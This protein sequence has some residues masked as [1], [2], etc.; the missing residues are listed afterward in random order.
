MKPNG[1]NVIFEPDETTLYGCHPIEPIEKV[2][3]KYAGF[4]AVVHG[5]L[6]VRV[7]E[8]PDSTNRQAVVEHRARQQRFTVLY[9]FLQQV[10]QYFPDDVLAYHANPTSP[11]YGQQQTG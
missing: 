3:Q 6:G 8:V 1:R 5:K 2:M 11:V 9:T 7:D 4:H 10:E